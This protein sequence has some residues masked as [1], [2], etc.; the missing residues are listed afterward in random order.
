MLEAPPASSSSPSERGVD[1]PDPVNKER[2]LTRVA[3]RL[4][5]RIE[6]GSPERPATLYLSSFDMI[7]MGSWVVVSE[8]DASSG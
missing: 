4:V 3:R 8:E 2:W 7:P 5:F 6:V 1:R